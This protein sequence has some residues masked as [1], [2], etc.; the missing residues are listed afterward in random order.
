MS[1]CPDLIAELDRLASAC[2]KADHYVWLCIHGRIPGPLRSWQKMR[3]AAED[4]YLAFRDGHGLRVCL[5]MYPSA[6]P[7]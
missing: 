2:R 5:C 6:F 4:R 1:D 7:S 3:D